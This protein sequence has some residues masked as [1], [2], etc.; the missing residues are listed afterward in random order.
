MMAKINF[1][2]NHITAMMALSQYPII[3]P[4][5]KLHRRDETAVKPHKKF[6]NLGFCLIARL[7]FVT[8]HGVGLKFC[9]FPHVDVCYK[10]Y[11]GRHSL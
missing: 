9:R 7:D 3:R 5:W 4:C 10:N 6:F 2:I 8:D 11:G 1:S